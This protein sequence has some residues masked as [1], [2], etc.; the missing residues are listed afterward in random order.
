MNFFKALFG[1]KTETPEEKKKEDE[2]RNFD[3]LKYDGVRAMR[4]GQPDYAVKCFRHA[5]EIKDDLEIR[6][7]L[8]QVL[9]HSNELPE[10][11]DELRKLAD[12]QPENQQIFIRMANVAFMMEDYVAM[13][14]AC[15][16]ALII[17][18]DNPL[19][20][21]LYARAVKGMGDVVNTIAMLTRAIT[22]DD[23]YGD[24]YLLRGSTLLEMGDV[25]GADADAQWLLDNTHDNEDVLLLKARIE[26]ARGNIDEAIA[27][28]N[29]VTEV[30]PFSI[31]AYKERGSVLLEKGDKAG[32]AADMQK[33][34]ELSPKDIA[35]INGDFSSEGIEAK[36]RKAYADNPL[37]LG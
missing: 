8:S 23:K 35:D 22:L 29:K 14:E 2:A 24:A 17:D 20:A 31:D 34:L 19:V 32:A 33:V 26:C 15:E 3:V 1:G 4:S 6:D 11:Y 7:Y 5:L 30:N 27:I 16:K 13:G 18:K 21:Y 12:A 28:Y 36:T 10:A 37:G 25:E 9:I